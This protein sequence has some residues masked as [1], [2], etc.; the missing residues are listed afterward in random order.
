MSNVAL[1]LTSRVIS[2]A[3]SPWVAFIP[4]SANGLSGPAAR[5]VAA[6]PS[7]PGGTSGP[8]AAPG[9]A[10]RMVAALPE[11]CRWHVRASTSR[12]SRYSCRHRRRH[13]RRGGLGLRRRGPAVSS[14]AIPGY[15]Q[16]TSILA[17]PPTPPLQPAAT[18]RRSCAFSRHS[19][20][21]DP[22]SGSLPQQ[23]WPANC[24]A[25][26]SSGS[27]VLP[28][29]SADWPTMWA[30]SR[31]S[32]VPPVGEG[33]AELGVVPPSRAPGKAAGRRSLL[34]LLGTPTTPTRLFT[35]PTHKGIPP[36]R[37]SNVTSTPAALA[38]QPASYQR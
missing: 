16:P 20:Q 28:T 18:T 38:G 15:G 24:F 2:A 35:D 4:R 7:A 37:Y 9:A 34:R 5:T 11:R 14:A 23:A 25:S 3:A 26:P 33:D 1:G 8:P 22:P 36:H 21:D 10:A 6:L 13:P 30:S 32:K 31:V 19:A 12:T 17:Q 27:L 29:F